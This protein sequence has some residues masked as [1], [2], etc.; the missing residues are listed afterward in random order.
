MDNENL[1]LLGN[2]YS[3]M[4]S[5]KDPLERFY[6]IIDS[7][8]ISRE[9]AFEIMFRNTYRLSYE[10]SDEDTR[11]RVLSG[12]F[13]YTNGFNTVL[14]VV[15]AEGSE[16]DILEKTKSVFESEYNSR[17]LADILRIETGRTPLKKIEISEDLPI[18]IPTYFVSEYSVEINIQGRDPFKIGWLFEKRTIAEEAVQTQHF[19]KAK[20][21]IDEQQF[22]DI[23]LELEIEKLVEENEGELH[24]VMEENIRKYLSRVGELNRMLKSNP[25][26]EEFCEGFITNVL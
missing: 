18:L 24:A 5:P 25:S 9:E 26:F 23:S 10:N 8:N 3:L 16:E 2:I 13:P 7:K 1:V 20:E 19:Q 15:I 4:Y 21:E 11:R 14:E 6:D 22:D 17:S 12:I